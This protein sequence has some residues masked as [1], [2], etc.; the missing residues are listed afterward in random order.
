MFYWGEDFKRFPLE[1]GAQ[2]WQD[3]LSLLTQYGERY[4]ALEFVKDDS[5][6][7]FKED[8]ATLKQLLDA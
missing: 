8:V 2:N 1:R 7:Q 4:Y 6:E 3:Y 5:L